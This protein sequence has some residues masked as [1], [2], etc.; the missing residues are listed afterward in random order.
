MDENKIDESNSE[1][2]GI[3]D[4]PDLFIKELFGMY[5]NFTKVHILYKEEENDRHS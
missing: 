5:D 3:V 2:F 1:G 4:E